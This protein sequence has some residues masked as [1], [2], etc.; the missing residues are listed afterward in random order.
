MTLREGHTLLF[1]AIGRM[2][3]GQPVI[4][5]LT[6]FTRQDR[7]Q[8][9]GIVVSD[10]QLT[11]PIELV[12]DPVFNSLRMP[13]QKAYTTIS[14]LASAV[15]RSVVRIEV[16]ANNFSVDGKVFAVKS[17]SVGTGFVI[18]EKGYIL[19]N[20]HVVMPPTL[21]TATADAWYEW[22][23][24]YEIRI[25]FRQG[26]ETS[27]PLNLAAKLHGIDKASDLAVLFV[28]PSEIS[29]LPGGDALLDKNG[30]LHALEFTYSAGVGEDVVAVGF[31]RGISGYPSVSRGIISAV[32]RSTDI[33]KLS[34]GN[35]IQTDAA[36][37]P[38]NSGGPLLNMRGEVVGVNNS[39]I[40]VF[41]DKAD[42][43]NSI[44]GISFARAYITGS[45]LSR[46]LINETKID[47]VELGFRADG[48]TDRI[49][50]ENL[51]NALSISGVLIRHKREAEI[52]VGDG[53]EDLIDWDVIYEIDSRSKRHKITSEGDLNDTIAFIRKDEDVK[54]RYY[55]LPESCRKSLAS[56]Q[57]KWSSTPYERICEWRCGLLRKEALIKDVKLILDQQ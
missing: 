20:A 37:N 21:D 53:Y 4:T 10:R 5:S 17:P 48:S 50:R 57:F 52:H 34:L 3:Y 54:V 49:E 45:E 13:S 15:M 22:E 51:A 26:A 7:D 28:D 46:I 6:Y 18:N 32:S 19:T 42:L 43:R 24:P 23:E 8:N 40:R 39:I 2:D 27:N 1:R 55:R 29:R 41:G 36:V 38:G 14:G 31:A 47:R 30:C 12:K 16:L 44:Q 33:G 56:Q 35:M 11:Y 25:E 9:S